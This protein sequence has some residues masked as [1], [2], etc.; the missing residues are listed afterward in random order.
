[1]DETYVGI[2]AC[3]GEVL[4]F[5]VGMRLTLGM[6]AVFGRCACSYLHDKCCLGVHNLH[7]LLLLGHGDMFIKK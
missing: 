1:M 3:V 6:S 2:E 7:V 4:Q 5:L